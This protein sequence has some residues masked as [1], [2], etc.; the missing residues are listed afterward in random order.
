MEGTLDPVVCASPASA[1]LWLCPQGSTCDVKVKNGSTF[2]GI[3]KTLS[4]KVSI[5]G[6]SEMLESSWLARPL[7]SRRLTLGTGHT[8]SEFRGEYLGS[9]L[10]S[11]RAGS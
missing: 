6:D 11:G 9:P 2:E 5:W 8:V 7:G 10:G 1:K 3:F 4:S